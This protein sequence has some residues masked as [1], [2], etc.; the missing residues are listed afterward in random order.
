MLQPGGKK[1]ILCRIYT[2]DKFISLCSLSLQ[3]LIN[4]QVTKTPKSNKK[5][6][7]PKMVDTATNDNIVVENIDEIVGEPFFGF[8]E[9]C[10]EMVA[11]NRDNLAASFEDQNNIK[12]G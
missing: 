3:Y 10:L 9:D 5:I 8:G 11:Q 2:S 6:D 7:T 4:F 1:R 12:I